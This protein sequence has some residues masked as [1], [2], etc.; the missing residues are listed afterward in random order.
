MK[1]IVLSLASILF[2]INFSYSQGWEYILADSDLN[3]SVQDKVIK[4]DGGLVLCGNYREGSLFTPSFYTAFVMKLSA[5]GQVEWINEYPTSSSENV[6]KG[7]DE[8]AA[9][10]LLVSL[11]RNDTTFL[12]K[13]S[14]DGHLIWEVMDPDHRKPRDVAVADN[15]TIYWS[16]T[17]SFEL[18]VMTSKYDNNGNLIWETDQFAG[19]I[20]KTYGQ[21]S[22]MCSWPET[23]YEIDP[24]TGS[25]LRTL[26]VMLTPDPDLNS[27]ITDL[28]PHPIYGAIVTGSWDPSGAVNIYTPRIQ[29]LNSA[30]EFEYNDNNSLL[31]NGA[32]GM[33]NGISPLPNGNYVL[34]YQNIFN[35]S[36]SSFLV[37]TDPNLQL[38]W[39]AEIPGEQFDIEPTPDGGFIGIVMQES[40]I[41]VRRF[42]EAGNFNSSTIRGNVSTGTDLTCPSPGTNGLPLANWVVQAL[43]PTD[44][45]LTFTD[46]NGSYSM[47]VDTGVF[48]VNILPPNDLWDLCNGPTTLTIDSFY[49]VVNQDF[50]VLATNFCSNPEITIGAPFLRQCFPNNYLVS[51]CNN[52]TLLYPNTQV[53]I[54]LDEFL[55]Y[56]NSSIPFASNNDQTF[57]YDIGDLDIG[58]CAEF[59]ISVLLNCDSEFM[60]T[61][62]STA[63]VLGAAPC[64]PPTPLW[65]E[66]SIQVNGT[67]D[68]DSV[69][70]SIENTGS[71]DMANNQDYLILRN[72]LIFDSGNFQLNSQ[73][74]TTFAFPADG[75]TWRIEADQAD[76]HPGNSQPSLSIEGCVDG[77]GLFDVGFVTIYDQDDADPFID[78]DCQQNIAAYD[79]NDKAAN[80]EGYGPD[81]LI[82]AN[83]DLTYK[84][85]FQN[86]GTDTAFN[87][88]LRDTISDKLDLTSLQ[89]GVSSHSYRYTIDNDNILR[90]NYDN[91]MLPDSNVNEPASNGFVQFRIKQKPDLPIGSRIENRAGIYFDFN[92]PII[93]NTVQHEIGEDF[94]I[95]TS[96]EPI[97]N[98]IPS[99]EVL[100]APNPFQEQTNI[101]VLTDR[102]DRFQF[103]VFNTTGQLV[104]QQ[105]FASNP[106]RY[107]QRHLPK[108]IY[109]YELR[110]EEQ[111]I[112]TGKLII[113]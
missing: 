105:V 42:D 95:L 80:P 23:W 75:G 50:S 14:S 88:V 99:V 98:P 25:I 13:L 17:G 63:R 70:F 83:T 78:I 68:V 96:I 104:D 65:D 66:S 74:A 39:R 87:I 36:P 77:G 56:I 94:F 91:I 29:Y 92:E 73:S 111:L 43:S 45:F 97:S 1:R 24:A 112:Q 72:D 90:I 71:G 20:I 82:E 86:T 37:V 79:P 35:T 18:D 4:Q 28:E 47:Q 46:Q 22:I 15:N 107:E 10:E 34:A 58:E 7:I 60:Q 110:S 9:A 89:M 62:C 61:H 53:E 38:I 81:H 76:D 2:L 59:Q 31:P 64:D 69:R 16:R 84:I 6:A 44:T 3:S 100:I 106:F 33:W 48:E 101:Q 8:N 11:S 32:A 109:F 54:T 27:V 5:S 108:G 41:W 103:A 52:G 55:D 85:R 93:T 26:P 30:G 21:D 40:F 67:C 19:E 113:Q 102:F 51:V 57:I 12:R 49:Q